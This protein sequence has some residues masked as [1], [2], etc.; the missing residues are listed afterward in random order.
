VAISP[1]GDWVAAGGWTGAA[2]GNVKIYLF[3][4]ATGEIEQRISGLPNVIL[5][6][7]YS[8]DGQRLVATLGRGEGIRLYRRRPGDRPGF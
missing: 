2:A 1:D 4:R 3:D 8:P 5:H 6:L 7:A